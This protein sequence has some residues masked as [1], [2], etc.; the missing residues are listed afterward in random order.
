MTN[1]EITLLLAESKL[2]LLRLYMEDDTPGDRNIL[3]RQRCMDKVAREILAAIPAIEAALKECTVE[4][5]GRD[6]LVRV[7]RRTDSRTSRLATLPALL[8]HLDA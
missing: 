2:Q 5:P 1:I 4:R 6:E 3:L 8:I 7:A